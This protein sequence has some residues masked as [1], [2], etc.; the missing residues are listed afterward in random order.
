MHFLRTI[1]QLILH[2]AT[3]VP[4]EVFAFIGSFLEEI[5]SPIPSA[6]VMGT[7]GSLAMFR[8]Q[9]LEYLVWLALVGS[10][11]KL[12]GAWFYY[13]VG[14]KLEDLFIKRL[15]KFFGVRHEEIENIG[16]R[17]VGHHWKD[18]GALFMLRIIPFFPTTPL[19][20]AAGIIKMDLRVFLIATYAANFFKDLLYLYAGYSGLAVLHRLGRV[21]SPYRLGGDIFVAVFIIALLAFLYIHRGRGKRLVGHLRQKLAHF[22]HTKRR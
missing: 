8:H 19:S 2:F 13:F 4:L 5:I 15:T 11:G 20:L 1:E 9:P 7:A 6:L 16:K 21:L 22:F 10:A 3:R 17:F 18:G 12:F 14:D